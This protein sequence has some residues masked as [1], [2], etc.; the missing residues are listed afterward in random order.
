MKIAAILPHLKQFGGVR[1]FLE[2]GNVLVGL[3][4][5]YTVVI[6]DEPTN[7]LGWFD[8]HGLLRQVGS[9]T[10][11]VVLIGDPPSF[12]LLDRFTCPK[13]VWVIA[14]GKYIPQYRRLYG[15][16]PFLLNNRVF[17]EDF[18]AAR[19][20]EGGVNTSHFRPAKLRVGYYAGRGAAKGEREILG[21]LMDHPSVRLL[22]LE[23]RN[24]NDLPAYYSSLD[25]FVAWEQR[26][27]WSNTAAEALACGVPVVTNG[28]NCEPFLTRC[29]VVQSLRDFFLD[30]MAD[31]SWDRVADR[32]I[33]IWTEDGIEIQ[34]PVQA[35][36]GMVP[37]T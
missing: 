8:F 9:E 21:Q 22:P 7:R 27:G 36:Q 1:R 13:Y 23:G 32:L 30:P 24:N 29:I 17:L 15:Q 18:P 3:G 37:R 10:Y 33:E 6:P 14:G 19:L 5:E 4:H 31:F 28:V 2:L 11:D 35:D 16:H 26:P 34:P 12:P 25:Y 20:V